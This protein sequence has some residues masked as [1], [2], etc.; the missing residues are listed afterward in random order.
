MPNLFGI[1]KLASY[2]YALCLYH[3]MILQYKTKN[4][5]IDLIH[6]HIALR[7]GWVALLHHFFYRTPYFITEQYSGYMPEAKPFKPGFGFWRTNALR[8]IFSRVSCFLPV[9]NALG[10]S[11]QQHFPIRHLQPIYNVV[12]MDIF[13]TD[14]NTPIKDGIPTFIH[15]STLTAQK[16]PED[17]LRAFH[18]L[19]HEYLQAFLLQ[20]VGPCRSDLKQLAQDLAIDDCIAWI[21]ETTQQSLFKLIQHA[22]ALVLYS[23]FETFGCVN[24]EAIASGIPV[25]VSDLPVFREY[26][27]EG[28]NAFFAETENPKQLAATLHKCIE[29]MPFN[30]KSIAATAHDFSY[31]HIGAKLIEIYKKYL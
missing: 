2:C 1:E 8:I 21:P 20:I 28:I 12:N 6:V 29:T 22:D 25:V 5:K 19:K 10:H 13:K 26:L 9:S 17:M 14:N 30:S 23:R 18:T 15:I 4:G 11:F 16:N 27:L 24:M 31:Q 7:A 3:K